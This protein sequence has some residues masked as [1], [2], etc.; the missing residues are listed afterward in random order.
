MQ[1]NQSDYSR[2]FALKQK[3]SLINT[4]EERNREHF[5]SLSGFVIA[6]N[7]DIVEL[8]IPYPIEQEA[9]NNSAHKIC[10][11][12]TSESLGNGIQV[13]TELVRVAA[14]NIFHLQLHGNLELF[15]RRKT[16]RVDTKIKLYYLRRDLSLTFFR[17]EWKR[18][19]EHMKTRGMPSNLVLHEEAVNLS[20]GGIRLSTE[21]KLQPSPL[22][23]FFLDLDDG[24]PPVCAL[25]ENV[26]QRQENKEL[27][28]GH[29]FIQILKSDQERISQYVQAAQK[30]LGLTVTAGKIN[31][32]LVDQMTFTAL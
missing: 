22:S 5:E 9:P 18:I 10:F 14:G 17:K 3:V 23:M 2:Y 21:S 30:R 6:R 31:W 28:C 24:Q 12:L 26:W 32:E 15:Q 16:S 29:R 13:M 7:G 27:I 19:V 4:S 11:K 20:M 8:H 1:S 25:A